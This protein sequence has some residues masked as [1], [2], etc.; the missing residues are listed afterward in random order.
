M[1]EE[2]GELRAGW[3]PLLLQVAHGESPEGEPAGWRVGV[4]APGADVAPVQPDPVSQGQSSH[5][6]AD[7][8]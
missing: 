7:L 2:L 8:V 3:Q 4:V 1:V 5:A 6:P